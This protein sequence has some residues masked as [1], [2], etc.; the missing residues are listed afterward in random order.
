MSNHLFTESK[1]FDETTQAL[2]SL[3]HLAELARENENDKGEPVV[4]TIGIGI[5]GQTIVLDA[6]HAGTLIATL[7]GLVGGA[8]V[9]SGGDC[10]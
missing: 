9:C 6:A 1:T 4:V 3:K 5:Q 10:K 2:Y 8:F 7:G